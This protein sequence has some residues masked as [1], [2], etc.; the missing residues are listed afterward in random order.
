[1]GQTFTR[2]WSKLTAVFMVVIHQTKK[3]YSPKQ[4]HIVPSSEGKQKLSNID[5]NISSFKI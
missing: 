5:S 1:M 4:V 2:C 3:K